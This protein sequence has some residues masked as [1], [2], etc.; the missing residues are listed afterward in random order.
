MSKISLA[1]DA[2]GSGI[3]TIASPNSNTN[4]TLTLPD[5]TGTIITSG[6]TTGIDASALSTGT[7]AA[8]RLPAGS[9][10][11][12]I[13]AVKTDTQST[14]SVTY[15]DVSGMSGATTLVSSTAGG[16]ADTND[17]WV[18]GGG[19]G[20]TFNDRKITSGALDYLDSPNTTS[21]TT[22]KIQF[23]VTT[24][25]GYINAWATNSD[26][27]AVSSITVMEIAA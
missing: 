4:R 3:F 21:A 16:Q 8:A 1:P 7:L 5:N 2:S 12:V 25:V 26:L 22:Y 19:G 20:T 15:V 11:Q 23:L 17:A 24:N 6:S 14:S 9:V 18:V 13:Q 10:L 27:A